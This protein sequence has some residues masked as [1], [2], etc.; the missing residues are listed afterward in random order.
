MALGYYFHPDAMTKPSV[1]PGRPDVSPV[2]NVIV[3]K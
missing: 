2:H 1:D 3:G